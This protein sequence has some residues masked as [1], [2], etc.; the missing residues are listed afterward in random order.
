MTHV[1]IHTGE[2]PFVCAVCSR[3]YRDRRELK[4]HQT[5]HNHSGQ[6]APIP[7]SGPVTI[8]PPNA[9]QSTATVTAATAAAA[10]SNS[11]AAASPATNHLQGVTKTIVVQQQPQPQSPPNNLVTSNTVHLPNTPVPK[12][13][14]NINGQPHVVS[15]RIVQ[16][17][18]LNPAN[19]ALP[20]SVASA[21][22]SI[23][24]RVTKQQRQKQIGKSNY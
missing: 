21:L 7:G 10:S 19:I 5:T 20:P 3:G 4:K 1:R 18:P 22:Q 13:M 11:V 15:Q 24:D 6:S 12:E 17:E 2:K 16:A 9:A 23:N 8:P 14:L